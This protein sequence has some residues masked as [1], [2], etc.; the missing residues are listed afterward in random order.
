M[1]CWY[2]DVEDLSDPA[3]FAGAMAT[4]PWEE[5]REKVMRYRYE[6]DK[7]LCLGAGLL[8]LHALRQ[9][10]ASDLTLHTPESGKPVLEAHPSLQFNL[11]HSGTLA[12]CAVSEG[13]V[14]VDV[15]ELRCFPREIETLCFQPRELTWLEFEPNRDLASLRLW[16]RK[17]SWIK[18]T[19]S[20][21]STAPNSFSAL[22]DQSPVP[23][24][25]WTEH[26]VMGHIICVCA[27]ESQ[28]VCFIPWRP[29]L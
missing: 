26:V 17:E 29:N 18:L 13:P 21:L 8:L 9:A 19:G 4:L 15:E 7:R 10:G 16:T 20:G 24:I 23:G 2:Y 5:R 14:G 12:V 3:R 22:P 1:N 27:Q 28:P 6:K 11:S 25:A